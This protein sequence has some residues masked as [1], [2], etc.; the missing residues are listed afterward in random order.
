MKIVLLMVVALVACSSSSSGGGPT[1]DT[2]LCA[3]DSDCGSK[4]CEHVTGKTTG[5][6]MDHCDV[7]PNACS[8]GFVCVGS[9]AI[10]LQASCLVDC[11]VAACADGFT[12]AASYQGATKVCI[13]TEWS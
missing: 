4:D 1:S 5:A 3:Q 9:V 13:P 6:C 7:N 11:S 10:K 8:P 2:K 12:C